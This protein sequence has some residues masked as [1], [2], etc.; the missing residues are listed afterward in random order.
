MPVSG[1]TKK[2]SL[3]ATKATKIVQMITETEN[4]CPIRHSQA[5]KWCKS[6]VLVP[7]LMENQVMPRSGAI[8]LSTD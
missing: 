2:S 6:F 5:S 7:K 4:Y 3:C 8:K 1:T